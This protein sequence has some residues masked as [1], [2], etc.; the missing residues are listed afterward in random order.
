MSRPGREGFGIRWRIVALVTGATFAT[1]L[2]LGIV[3]TNWTTKTALARAHASLEHRAAVLIPLL[4]SAYAELGDDTRVIAST[5][6]IL[7]IA[8][9][10]AN[11]GIDP[12]DGSSWQLW[13]TRLETIFTSFLAR[14]PHYVQ[15]RYISHAEDAREIVRVDA[16][17]LGP[18][19]TIRVTPIERLQ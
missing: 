9:S 3:A 5:P 12:L 10:S 4:E 8:R 18:D 17:G 14:R 13:R 11:A 19:R 15:I 1:A 7:G 16:T 2:G 6:P